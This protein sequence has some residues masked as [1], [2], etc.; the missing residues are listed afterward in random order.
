MTLQLELQPILLG[1]DTRLSFES[2]A[3]QAMHPCCAVGPRALQQLVL[4][5][6][7][8]LGAPLPPWQ[9][10]NSAAAAGEDAAR[11]EASGSLAQVLL[12]QSSSRQGELF[13]SAVMLFVRHCRC[14]LQCE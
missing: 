12:Q 6:L 5:S 3:A 14:G 10:S 8:L 9:S 4:Q 2:A 13:M 11:E 1:H 7:A